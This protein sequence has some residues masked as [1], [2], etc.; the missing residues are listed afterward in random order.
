MPTTDD[1]V[2]AITTHH[3]ELVGEVER[4]TGAVLAAA[5]TGAPHE[6]AVRALRSLLD[7]DVV[8]HARAEEEV[9]YAAATGTDVRAL[10]AGMILEHEALLSLVMEL[11]TAPGAVDAAGIARAVREIFVGHVRRENELLLPA[12]ALDPD[13]DLPALLPPMQERFSAHQAAA[14]AP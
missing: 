1:V 14:V 11:R 9:L 7:G 8:P 2:A 6:D 12:L 13:V 10:V 4:R 3:S 5:R